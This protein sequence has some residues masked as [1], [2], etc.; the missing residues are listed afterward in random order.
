[1]SVEVTLHVLWGTVGALSLHCRLIAFS[2]LPLHILPLP[3]VGSKSRPD[4]RMRD[5]GLYVTFQSFLRVRYSSLSLAAS[6]IS[7]TPTR[8]KS[9]SGCGRLPSVDRSPAHFALLSLSF[10]LRIPRA[11]GRSLCVRGVNYPPRGTH[12][13][14]HNTDI[15]PHHRA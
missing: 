7:P 3:R 15:T 1:M 14:H 12:R 13:L 4:S 9:P 6:A 5:N 2:T 8:S 10:Y 11:R